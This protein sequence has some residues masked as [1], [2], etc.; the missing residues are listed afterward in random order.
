MEYKNV[1]WPGLVV[2]AS[3]LIV[4]VAH[5]SGMIDLGAHSQSSTAKQPA[6]SLTS[7]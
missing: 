2:A 4:L 6:I 5:V 1:D 3:L 7:G